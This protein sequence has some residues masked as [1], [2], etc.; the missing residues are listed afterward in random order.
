MADSLLWVLSTALILV[1]LAGIARKNQGKAM[2]VGIATWLRLMAGM[3][4]KFVLT[5]M[6]IGL[7]LTA[8]AF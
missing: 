3:L 7:Y 4:A 6:M 2:H 1:G 5:F 8:L